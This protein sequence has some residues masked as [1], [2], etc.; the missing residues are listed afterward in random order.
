MKLFRKKY[1]DKTELQKLSQVIAAEE[2]RTSGEI[3]VVLKRRRKW[4]ERKASL[5]DLALAEFRA[6]GMQNTRDRTGVLIM[7]LIADR[8]FQIIA[9]EG[10]N[11]KVK[12][13]TWDRIADSMSGY[14]REEKYFEGLS[15]A[16][17][18]VGAELAG[19]F[20]RKSDDT[21]ELSNEIVER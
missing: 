7:I 8:K 9:D 12:A 15:G 20:P 18:A 4:S 5:S 21:D 1:L 11:R 2:K 13:G 10:I 3:R 17:S 14:F 16:I 6:L 19:N